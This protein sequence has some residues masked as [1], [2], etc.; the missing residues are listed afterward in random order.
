MNTTKEVKVAKTTT[1]KQATGRRKSSVARLRISAGKGEITC[2]GRKFEDYFPFEVHRMIATEPLRA[3]NT[4]HVYDVDV[5][6]HGGGIAGQAG[7]LRHAIARAIVALDDETRATL[8]K[9]GFLT[10]DS[11]EKERK[12]YGLKKARKS[13]QFSKR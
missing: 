7:A 1:L 9:A 13:P 10:R 2:N 4:D 5:T 6:L 8:K 12:K 11:R 3:T